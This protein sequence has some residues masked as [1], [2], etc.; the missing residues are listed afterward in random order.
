MVSIKLAHGFEHL[1]DNTY[2]VRIDSEACSDTDT[3]KS[4]VDSNMKKLEEQIRKLRSSCIFSRNDLDYLESI[5]DYVREFNKDVL[6]S[7]VKCDQSK[8]I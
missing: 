1:I 8:K 2:G 6:N 4:I 3:A 5:L 7:P